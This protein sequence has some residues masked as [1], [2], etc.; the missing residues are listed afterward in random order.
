MARSHGKILVDIWLDMDFI[1]LDPEAQRAF[2]MLLSQPKLTLVGSI[3]YRP[4][5]W[6]ELSA[7]TTQDDVEAAVGRLEVARFVCVDRSTEELLVR[8]MTRHDGLR[9]GNPK[10]LKGLWSAWKSIAS[11]GL[12]KVAVDNMPASLFD[13]PETPPSAEQM[14]RS[15]R[16]DWPIGNPTDATIVPPS[17]IHRPPSAV[18]QSVRQSSAPVDNLDHPPTPKIPE[19]ARALAASEIPLL[20]SQRLVAV[21][22]DNHAA[23]AGSCRPVAA[24]TSGAVS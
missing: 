7:A 5:H 12:R 15:A 9:S 24:G 2:F 16:M 4:H 20:R 1:A 13:T 21:P 23:G 22:Q 3:D 14:R 11:V 10:L 19:D 18:A 8:S 6:A 17:A